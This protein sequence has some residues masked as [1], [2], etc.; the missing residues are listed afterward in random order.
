MRIL[1]SPIGTADPLTQLGDGP[2]LHIVRQ[3]EPEKVV[4]F[5]SPAMQ[6]HHQADNR[7]VEAIHLLSE[8][9]S[10][11]MPEIQVIGSPHDNV[12]RF[13][14]YIEEFEEILEEMCSES[15]DEPVLVNVSSGTPGMQQALVALGAFGRLPLELLQVTT[16]RNG[17]NTR[18]DRE[19]PNRYDLDTLWIINEEERASNPETCASRIVVVQSPHFA[20]RVMRENVITLVNDYEYEAA[21]E[22]AT[23]TNSISESAKRMIQAAADRLNLDGQLPATVFAKTDLAYRPN[24]LLAEYISVMEVRLNQGHWADFMRLLTPAWTQLAKDALRKNGLPESSYLK[25][26]HGAPTNEWNWEAIED[27]EKLSCILDPSRKTRYAKN[28]MLQK[29]IR[30]YCEDDETRR[31]LCRLYEVEGKHRH[32]L[33]HAVTSSS[34]R[35]LEQPG[36][37]TLNEIL[38]YLFELHGNMRIHLYADINKAIIVSL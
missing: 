35:K 27:D 34:K 5:L 7:Y 13:D 21:Y 32:E 15:P 17:I 6:V 38:D 12:Y 20:D 8:S 31:K 18:Q 14:H 24:D 11:A 9:E 2:M 10:R 16:P 30:N 22:L 23:K 25:I 1:F 36:N 4:L 19:D 29:L 3:R 28:G 33:A 26:E 37:L